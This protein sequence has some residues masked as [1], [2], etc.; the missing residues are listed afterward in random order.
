VHSQRG[1]SPKNRWPTAPC[2][3]RNPAGPRRSSALQPWSGIP[4]GTSTPASSVNW[5]CRGRRD[6]G[7]PPYPRIRRTPLTRP[8][9]LHH[10]PVTICLTHNRLPGPPAPTGPSSL[11]S[12]CGRIALSGGSGFFGCGEP[13]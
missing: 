5:T 1:T 9:Q 6:T 11:R 3:A 12:S 2:S 8:R 4:G 7:L 10:H 13:L